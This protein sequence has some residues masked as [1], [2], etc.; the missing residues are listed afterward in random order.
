MALG[1]HPNIVA[2]RGPAA[3]ADGCIATVWE[4]MPGKDLAHWLD[5]CAPRL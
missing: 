3:D 5:W 2:Y 1:S 4:Y